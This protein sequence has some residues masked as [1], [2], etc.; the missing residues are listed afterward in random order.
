MRAM[1]Y[2][3]VGALDLYYEDYGTG[4]STLVMA[5]GALGSVAFAETFGL[6]A[7]VLARRGLRVI[8]YDARGH[9]RSGFSTVPGDYD[10]HALA[11][12]LRL[13][14]D[15]LGLARVSLCGT[16]M[17]A[18]SA[19]LF[20]QA[21]PERV[22]R[23]VLRSPAPFGADMVP[24]RRMLHGLALSYQ[25]L[26]TSL[27]AR[28]ASVRP[29]PGGAVRMRALLQG[30]R[31]ASIVPALRGFLAE[32]L[33]T[34]GLDTIE[35]PTLILTQPADALHPLRSGELLYNLLP[36]ATS[37]VAPTATFWDRRR[38][39]TA[40]LIAAFVSGRDVLPGLFA[41]EGPC[42]FRTK[43]SGG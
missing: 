7:A 14:L 30:Q 25:V 43:K 12:E 20:A 33:D 16:S 23:L 15:V 9:G 40:D 13:L 41:T 38:D 17:G 31:R 29:G 26:G 8:A 27:T 34:Q 24:A 22:E 10:K 35:S 18:T 36:D 37:C 28:L 39:E 21:H 42:T 32:P 19:L 2:A 3:R 1:P 6:S 5:H 4:P 11:I